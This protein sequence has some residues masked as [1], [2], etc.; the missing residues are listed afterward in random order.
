MK[1]IST[2]AITGLL[3]AGTTL[4]ARLGNGLIA[5][6]A[7]G[8]PLAELA[9]LKL[10]AY[11][12]K[13]AT[14]IV[15][16]GARPYIFAVGG[17]LR[18]GLLGTFDLVLPSSGKMEIPALN[19]PPGPGEPLLYTFAVQY[20]NLGNFTQAY[21][22]GTYQGILSINGRD[23]LVYKFPILNR[24]FPNTPKVINWTAGQKIKASQDFTLTWPKFQNAGPGA[25][26]TLIVTPVNDPEHP[27]IDRSPLTKT[28]SPNVT[29][30]T[31]PAG[32]LKPG[33]TYVVS[34]AFLYIDSFV[35]SE[36]VVSRISGMG[37]SVEALIKTT[38]LL[39]GGSGAAAAEA[40]IP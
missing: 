29:S 25:S 37:T 5:E 4:H 19:F 39:L 2:I 3:L 32:R 28:I 20:R 35:L 33:Q 8:N 10:A 23:R 6:Q 12:Q 22:G 34:I 16:D 24:A 21:P 31:I 17:I 7:N 26:I 27:V 30:Y 11:D 15:P 13:S 18:P 36:N 9:V 14:D 40:P 38:P 1:L